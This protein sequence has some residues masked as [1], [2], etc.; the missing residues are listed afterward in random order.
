MM[1]TDGFSVDAVGGG[2][3]R[4]VILQRARRIQLKRYGSFEHG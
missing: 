3:C 4:E 2:R 1:E